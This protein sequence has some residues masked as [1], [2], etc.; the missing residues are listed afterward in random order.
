MPGMQD[1]RFAGTVVYVCE[2][3]DKGAMG[4][5]INRPIDLTL[6]RLFERVDLSLEIGP[7]AHE[8]VYFGGPV[9]PERGFVLHEAH[10]LPDH[11]Y[12]SCVHVTNEVHL[13]TSKDVLQALSKGAGPKRVLVTLG[14]AGWGSGQLEK[15]IAANGW[16]TVPADPRVLFNVHPD[17]RYAAAVRLLGFDPSKLSAEVGHA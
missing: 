10:G 14:Y 13:T 5:V 2:H 9:Q 7:L 8:P 15:E 1:A 12:S 16:L 17:E 11:L 6:Q 4:L 3:N